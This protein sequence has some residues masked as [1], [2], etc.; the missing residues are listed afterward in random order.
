EIPLM[1]SSDVIAF[2]FRDARLTKIGDNKY[3][4]RSEFGKILLDDEKEELTELLKSFGLDEDDF[5][6]ST[7]EI[8][9]TIHPHMVAFEIIIDMEIEEIEM[10][11]S[12]T[13]EIEHDAFEPID[14]M[15]RSKFFPIYTDAEN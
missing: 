1:V 14:E 10:V 4:A 12:M 2:D 3:R 8:I 9:Y 7:V 5:F 6:D 13:V 15:D 11:I